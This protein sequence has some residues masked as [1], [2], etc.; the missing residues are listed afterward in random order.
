VLGR[1]Q[2]E[3]GA[4]LN[5]VCMYFSGGLQPVLSSGADLSWYNWGV[6]QIADGTYT[7]TPVLGG[8]E[9]TPPSLTSRST[10]VGARLATTN[11]WRSLMDAG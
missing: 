10:L 2:D 3:H 4:L 6:S 8:W 1:V 5:G 7:V 11:I 9:F